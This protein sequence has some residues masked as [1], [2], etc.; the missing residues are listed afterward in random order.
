MFSGLSRFNPIEHGWAPLSRWLAGVSLPNTLPDENKAPAEQSGLTDEELAEKEKTV[1]DN[2]LKQLNGYWN[3]KTYDEHTVESIAV[4][5][6]DC[7]VQHIY[8]DY[9]SVKKLFD[10]S[11]KAI[12]AN[13]NLKSLQEEWNFLMKHADRRPGMIMF[14]KLA[15]RDETCAC[16]QTPIK[17]TDAFEQLMKNEVN[18]F[19]TITPDPAH[20]DH[21]MTYER[22]VAAE[23]LSVAGSYF[24]T[25]NHGS[26]KKCRYVFSSAKDAQRHKAMIHKGK[27]AYD[28]MDVDNDQDRSFIC[29]PCNVS[30][31]TYYMAY[32]HRKE[33]GHLLPNGRPQNLTLELE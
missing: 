30:F 24:S 28:A 22:L 3:K 17:A 26:C 7:P 11:Q 8:D 20:P 13:P 15:C 1:F 31:P 6:R 27:R 2:A 21:Y 18:L 9:E 16:F 29:G 23:R 4:T 33:N 19:P 32:R 12:K 25:W 5:S 10:S 14:S